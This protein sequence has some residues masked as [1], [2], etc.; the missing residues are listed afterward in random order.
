MTPSVF[1]P[2]KVENTEGVFFFRKLNLKIVALT[3]EEN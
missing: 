2:L 3:F 1:S